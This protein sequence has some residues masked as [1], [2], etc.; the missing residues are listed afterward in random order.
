MNIEILYFDGCPTY[1]RVEQAL[2]EV[3][4][5]EVITAAVEMV[6]VNTDE[7]AQRLEVPGSPTIRVDGRDLFPTADRRD[8]RM[9]CRVYTTPEG[10]RG[11][12][13]SKM[14][15]EAIES[16]QRTKHA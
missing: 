15:R 10:V 7:D 2:R 9:G 14:L 6:A 3:V 13:T 4:A 12:P 11:H 1:Q 8:Y 16:H 5:D